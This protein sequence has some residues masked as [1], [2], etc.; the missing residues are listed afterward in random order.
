VTYH[1]FQEVSKHRK[2]LAA[3]EEKPDRVKREVRDEE[4]MGLD[5]SQ[6]R[7]SIVRLYLL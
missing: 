2:L 1:I 6:K 7:L 5:S 3:K 4:L